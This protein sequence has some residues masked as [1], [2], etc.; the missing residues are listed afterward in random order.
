MLD[1][2]KVDRV[3]A[4]TASAYLSGLAAGYAQRAGEQEVS[5]V[6][7]GPT[8]HRVPVRSTGRVLFELVDEAQRQLQLMTYSARRYP[9]LTRALQA[10][11]DRGVVIDAVVETLHG[12]G[13]ALSETEPASAFAEV[14][15]IRIWH[16]PPGGRPTG[17]KT[18]AKLVVADRYRLLT[19]SANLTRSGADRNIEA[20][21]LVSGGHVPARASEHIEELQRTGV[22][23]RYW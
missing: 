19:T 1:S 2:L 18:H 11:I 23:Q 16:W 6:W 9:P 14:D 5:L 4:E 17:A 20:G 13:S 3:P 15:G 22:L 10:A 21:V 8:S 12:A 7:S